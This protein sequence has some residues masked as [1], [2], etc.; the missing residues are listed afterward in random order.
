MVQIL[1]RKLEL[2]STPRLEVHDVVQVDTVLTF[3]PCR[4]MSIQ[5]GLVEFG[6]N[7]VETLWKGKDGFRSC[8]GEGRHTTPSPVV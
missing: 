7:Q 2:Q 4:G 8:V 5:D 3:V 1:Q 6:K